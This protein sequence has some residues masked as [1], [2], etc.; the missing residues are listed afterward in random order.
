VGKNK[1]I[2]VISDMHIPYH[3]PD[4]VPFLRA[5]KNKYKPDKWVCIG[6]ELDKHAMSF[7]DS[8]PDLYSA[9]HELEKSIEV[10]QPIY[11]MIPE[12]DL[13]ESNHGSM[14]F[15]KAKAHGI[16][17]AYFKDYRDMIQAPKGWK[18]SFD[19]TL[20]LPDGQKV[21]FC[22]GKTSNVLKLSQNMGMSACQGHYHSSFNIQYWGNPNGLF[23]GFQV[24]CLIDT[25]ALA[26]AYNKTTPNRPV[27]GMGV[28]QNGHPR[29]VPLLKD[30]HGRWTGK[31]P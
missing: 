17:Q 6:D 1:S 11:K 14:V 21:Y 15:R 25:D 24:G 19:L 13:V 4:L 16:P 27:I 26:F 10:L 28:I 5:V 20:K 31:L 8:D 7:H 3:H 23:W 18:W 9:G 22:H 2:A 29:L 12:M 30:H